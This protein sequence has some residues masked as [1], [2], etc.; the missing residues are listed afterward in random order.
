MWVEVSFN[1][2]Y[3]IVVWGLVLEMFRRRATVLPSNRAVAE[4][5]M[6]AFALLALGD[7]GHVGFRV[8]AY[9]LGSLETQLN[10]FGIPLSL[11]GVGAFATS[12]TVTFFYMLTLDI[13]RVR[14]N[15][16]FGVFEYGLLAAGV[17]RLI[18][19]MFPQNEWQSSVP[20]LSWSLLRNL[21]LVIQG[22]GVM[23][24]IWRDAQ[25]QNDQ[26]FKWIAIMIAISYACYTP[27]ILLVQQIPLIGMLMIPKTMAY[28][29][30]A[31]IAFR[32]LYMP[33]KST[34]MHIAQA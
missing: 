2:I 10:V 14:F 5:V 4:R 7:T 31:I 33:H 30:V 1:V 16:V 13:W 34:E 24:L 26:S 29:G 25:K 19:I 8:W 6:W 32:D 28:L 21:P 18:I 22:L 9:A 15:K 12:V 3:L 23:F 27:V 17:V 20:P 11:V